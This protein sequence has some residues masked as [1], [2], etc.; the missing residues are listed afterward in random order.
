MKSPTDSA[1]SV[2]R[3][4][5]LQKYE[6]CGNQPKFYLQDLEFPLFWL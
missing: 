6:K 5:A 1:I 4:Y 2:S 3:P